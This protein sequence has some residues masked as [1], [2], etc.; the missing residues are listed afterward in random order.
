MHVITVEFRARSGH[1]AD[2]RAR[3]QK[4]ASNSLGREE[5]CIQFDVSVDPQDPGR[6]FLY[7]VYRDQAAFEAHTKTPH[8]AEFNADSADW[9]DAKTI[10]AWTRLD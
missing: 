10:T 6:L 8:F 2:L 4:H 1:E 9:V 3:L 5:G 7:E